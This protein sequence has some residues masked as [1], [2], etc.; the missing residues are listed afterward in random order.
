MFNRRQ[1]TTAEIL[2]HKDF[3]ITFGYKV[4][5]RRFATEHLNHRTESGVAHRTHSRSKIRVID[6]K[7]FVMCQGELSPITA[8]LITLDSGTTF[9]NDIRLDNKYLPRRSN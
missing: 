6:G 7:P 1:A 5:F 4:L 8:D 3:N 2:H 9:L